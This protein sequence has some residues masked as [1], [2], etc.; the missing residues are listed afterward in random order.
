M[1]DAVFY[2][3]KITAEDS[4]GYLVNVDGLFVSEKLDPVKPVLPPTI[5]PG[6]VFNLGNFNV[7]KSGYEKIRSFPNNTDVVV[8]LAYDNP[9]P[10]NY[11]DK[12]ITDARYVRVK[13][14]HSFLEMPD[15]DYQPRFDDPRVGFF[16][17]EMDDMTSVKAT[18]YHDLI[19]RWYLKK[20]D[21]TAALSEPVEPIVWWVENTTPVEL[22]QVIMDAGNQWNEAFEKAGF[23]NAVVMKMMPDTATWDPADIR[24]NVIRWVSS[25]LGYAIGPSFVNPR[26]GQIL[27]SDITIDFG[28]MGGIDAEDELYDYRAMTTGAEA[29]PLPQMKKNLMTCNIG[30]GLKMQY[31]AGNIMAE[32]MG[33]GEADLKTLK[34]QFFTEL[35]LHEMGHTMGLMHNMK[36]SHMLS[37]AELHDKTITRKYGLTGSVMDYSTVNASLDPA[38]QGDYYTTKTGP[39][40][41]WA[42]EY[43]YSTFAASVEKKELQKILNR[44][45][46]TQLI[47]G[48]DADITSYSSGID[49]RVNVWDMSND[50][51]TY[52]EERFML[53]NKLMGKL[54]TRY[55]KPENSYAELRMKYNMLNNQRFSMAIPLSKYI[56]GI[57]VDRSFAGQQT[58]SK[59]YTPVPVDYQKKAMRVLSKYVFAPNAFDADTYLWPYLQRQRRSFNFFGGTEDLKIANA[60]LAMQMSTLT[61]I[62]S[63]VNTSRINNT[64]LYGNTYSVADVMSDLV[65]AIFD[66]DKNTAVNLYRQNLQTEFVKA[67]AAILNTAPGYDNATKAAS[68]STLKKVKSMLATTTSPNEQTKAHRMNLQFIIEKALLVK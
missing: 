43:G 29:T 14:Q 22:R 61:N 33:A 49:P 55:T 8:S 41:W 10:L 65:K 51:V 30:K 63:P 36:S 67:G 7:D 56:G 18:N 9:A 17:Q 39:Y 50:M 32:C 5:P 28:F 4:T 57:Y 11:G 16:T 2:T 31:A 34:E 62:L 19:N 15:N 26:T 23:K 44:S 1:G 3:S 12:S 58:T 48:N 53:V 68:L 24:Y 46:D 40:D 64:S 25:D 21:S 27:G 20:K 47:F 52:G 42:I 37:P 13:M 60:V 6:S 59:P 66:A 45:T 54:K 35:T 38:K